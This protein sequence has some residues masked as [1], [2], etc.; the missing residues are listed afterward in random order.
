MITDPNDSGEQDE[1][2]MR[3]DLVHYEKGLELAE[4]GKYC[5]ALEYM[6]EHL[7]RTPDDA[8][9]LNDTGA[10]LYCLGR[11]DE[12]IDHFVKARSTRNDSAETLWNLAEAYLATGKASE[13]A[14]IFDDMDRMG[15]LNADLLNR[16]AEV[17]LNQNNK[18]GALEML[19]RSLQ[20]WSDQEVLRPMVDIIRS[21]RPKVAFLFKENST[22]AVNE[23]AR[24]VKE[25]FVVRF[26]EDSGEDQVQGLIEWSDIAWF[27][28]GSDLAV[29][30]S[31]QVKTCKTII[32]PYLDEGNPQWSRA[33]NW[34]NIDVLVTVD[35]CTAQEALAGEL[36]ELESQ[37][38]IAVIPSDVNLERSAE[39]DYPQRNQLDKINGL[40]IELE[41]E[42]ESEQ[43]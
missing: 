6:Q 37:T 10:I 25:R 11:S 17:F 4:A 40:L 22:G 33:V 43:E 18:A 35:G 1:N 23:I 14:E 30:A 42:I 27:E 26:L 32:G 31:K 21:K 20:V 36:P 24:F 12:A 5:Q 7:R 39:E 29:T 2:V 8:E 28:W 3:D 19:L 16:T 41:A 15:V 13:A 38:S 9:V 34:T